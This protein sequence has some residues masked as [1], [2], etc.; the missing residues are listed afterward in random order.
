MRKPR[1]DKKLNYFT[2]MKSEENKKLSSSKSILGFDTLSVTLKEL[3]AI[4]NFNLATEIERIMENN[5]I[6]KPELHN[7]QNDQFTDSFIIDLTSDQIET[8]ADHFFDLE[9]QHIGKE[10]ETTPLCAYYATL[11]D[12]WNNLNN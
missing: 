10:G 7:K 12:D 2:I 4:N 6:E 11:A 3:N 8:I 1:L 5:K 9:V